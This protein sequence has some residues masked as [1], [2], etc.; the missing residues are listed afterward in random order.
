MIHPSD[1]FAF[2]VAVFIALAFTSAGLYLTDEL[3]TANQL[4]QLAV[5]HQLT[6]HEDK[7]GFYEDGTVD[8]SITGANYVMSYPLLTPMISL[9]V[10]LVATLLPYDAIRFVIS[11]FW[12]FVLISVIIAVS[13]FYRSKLSEKIYYFYGII[14]IMIFLSVLFY[15]PFE[16]TYMEVLS[17][18]TT[19][20]IL[21]GVFGAVIWK[22]VSYMFYG[23]DRRIFMWIAIMSC[24]SLLFWVGTLKD[25]M[26]IALLFMVIVYSMIKFY[27]MNDKKHLLYTAVASGLIIWGRPELSIVIIP[28]VCSLIIYKFR[29]RCI[30]PLYTYG[31]AIG[32]SIIP[33]FINNYIV[34]GSFIKFPYQA[35]K[36]TMGGFHLESSNTIFDVLLNEIP[37]TIIHNISTISIDNIIGILVYPMNGGVGLLPIITM[38]VITLILLPYFIFVKK[39]KL[40]EPEKILYIFSFVA[41]LMYLFTSVLGFFLHAEKGILPDMR[42]FSLIYAPMM[43]AS[44]SILSRVYHEFNYKKLIRNL[45]IWFGIMLIIFTVAVSVLSISGVMTVANVNLTANII[46]IVVFAI[47]VAFGLDVI[48][49]NR[50]QE[51]ETIIPIIISIPLTWQIFTAVFA[52]KLYNYPMYISLMELV[53]VLVFG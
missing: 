52:A 20:I 45:L 14:G 33:M 10:Y 19:N 53:K 39:I 24:S 34:T 46:G 30:A 35:V 2:C 3:S 42:Y 49:T 17:I 41:I 22:T 29:E 26:L 28:I 7:Y 1:I 9:P 48:R 15:T 16:T 25:H 4:H 27:D 12:F 44:L 37:A 36:Q 50:Y 23:D 11:I 40:I 43:V 31:L 47:S 38:V 5:G 18:V 6:F 51:F 21:Y 8:K 32:I 13:V